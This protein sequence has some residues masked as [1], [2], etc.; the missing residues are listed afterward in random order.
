MEK[1]A[2][3]PGRLPTPYHPR[4]QDSCPTPLHAQCGPTPTPW[5]SPPEQA[6]A[7]PGVPGLADTSAMSRHRLLRIPRGARPRWKL[8]PESS[9]TPFSWQRLPGA[10]WVTAG[11]LEQ[12]LGSLCAPSPEWLGLALHSRG[13]CLLLLPPLPPLPSALSGGEGLPP[14]CAG[15]PQPVA[16]P[17]KK[18]GLA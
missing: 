16:D 3:K 9:Q 14:R 7:L 15:S 10:K 12:R 18:G 1:Q 13:L 11:H 2:G 4:R 6:R 5:S 8:K 17:G